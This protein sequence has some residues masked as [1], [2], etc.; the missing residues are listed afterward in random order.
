MTCKDNDKGGVMRVL[1]SKKAIVALIAAVVA[2][3]AL[4]A[5]ALPAVI[6]REVIREGNNI[7]YQF[8]RITADGLDSG[9]HIHPG[10]VVVRVLEGSLQ[11]TA[12]ASCAPKTVAAGET[13]IEA[14]FV[15]IRAVATGRVV[16][17]VAQFVRDEEPLMS[18][19]ASPCP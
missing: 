15:P 16:F 12:Q 2:A 5:V 17:I 6:G 7:H 3:A 8:A 9:W 13:Y 19:V 18:P 10:L 11:F 1:H 4:A 14:P